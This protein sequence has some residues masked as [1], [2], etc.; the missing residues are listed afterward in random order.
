MDWITIIMFQK[1][2]DEKCEK[3]MSSKYVYVYNLHRS[4]GVWLVHD[5]VFWWPV[6]Y[7]IIICSQPFHLAYNLSQLI[8]QAN[9]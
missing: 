4:V 2:T 7:N 5:Q 6:M 9:S 1:H 8:K 3:E